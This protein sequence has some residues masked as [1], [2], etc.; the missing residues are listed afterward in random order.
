M[1]RFYLRAARGDAGTRD[2]REA[3]QFSVTPRPRSVADAAGDLA[4][5]E[6]AADDPHPED[7]RSAPCRW[8]P[9]DDD[10]IARAESAI[11]LLDYR[12]DGDVIIQPFERVRIMKV[13]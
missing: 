5:G 4:A 9:P 1:H 3:L 10:F 8:L 11:P 2:D 12:S 7:E 13:S 6:R